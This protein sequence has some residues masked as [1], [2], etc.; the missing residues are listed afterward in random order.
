MRLFKFRLLVTLF[1]AAALC[2]VTMGCHRLSEKARQMPG[3]YYI[4]EISQDLPLLEL[5]DDAT[6]IVRAIKPGILTYAVAGRWDVVGDS[7][8]IEVE[9]VLTEL[10]GD[11]SLVGDIP[12]RLARRVQEFTGTSLTLRHDGSDYVYLRRIPVADKL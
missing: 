4:N 3:H 6:C 1:A 8:V 11:S 2:A 10:Q 9:P 12:A 7:L 5:N